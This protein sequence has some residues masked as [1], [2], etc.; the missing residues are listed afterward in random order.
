MKIYSY[1]YEN[2]SIGSVRLIDEEKNKDFDEKIKKSNEQIGYEA[3]K[4]FDIPKEMEEIILYLLGEKG[5]KVYSDLDDLD[6]A[7]NK[8]SGDISSL[9]DDAFE[10]SE[11][12]EKIEKMFEDFKKHFPKDED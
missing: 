2:G 10:M 1:F 5:Y 6:N 8:V 7:L 12:I 3:Y 9:H 11:R 4:I